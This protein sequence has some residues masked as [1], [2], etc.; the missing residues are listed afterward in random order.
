MYGFQLINCNKTPGGK[1]SGKDINKWLCES[2]EDAYLLVSPPCTDEGDKCELKGEYKDPL[3]TNP[4]IPY[5]YVGTDDIICHADS[6]GSTVYVC[7]SAYEYINLGNTAT[8]EQ[9]NS[10]L[11]C[12]NLSGAY[13][14]LSNNLSVL[15]SSG[16]MAQSSAV[17]L[18]NM[19]A[20]L[21]GI[22]NIL[23]ES[24]NR[25]VSCPTLQ[26]QLAA[27]NSSINSGSTRL[28]N[29][30]NPY[31]IALTSRTNLVLQMKSMGCTIPK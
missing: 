1:K 8:K 13:I 27:L 26:S 20:T 6:S 4:N 16:S 2:K 5:S 7:Q 11:T 15:Q 12:D 17:R 14:D 21:Q 30:I 29:I 10:Q 19:Q 28:A 23:C 31:E 25:M 9:V 24:S 18:T 22:Y 3:I